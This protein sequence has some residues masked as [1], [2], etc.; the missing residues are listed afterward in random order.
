MNKPPILAIFPQLPLPE[1]AGDRQKVNNLI[2]VLSKHYTINAVVICRESY[3][4]NDENFLSQYCHQYKIFKLSKIGILYNCLKGF[5]KGESLQLNFFYQP[6]IDKYINQNTSNKHF[7]F[8]NLIRTAKYAQHYKGNKVMDMVDLISLSY[9]RSLQKVHSPFWKYIYKYENKHL[10]QAEEKVMN[11]FKDVFL[12]NKNEQELLS[13]KHSNIFWLPN[14]IKE[15]L[16]TNYSNEITEP[17]AIVF[18]GKMDYPPNVDAVIW[19]V[20]N[21]F[22]HLN[23]AIKFYIVGARPSKKVTALSNNRVIVTGYVSDPY[24]LMSNCALVVSPMQTGGGIQN[25]ILEGMALGKINVAT[26]LGASS[27]H[28]ANNNEHL[29]VEDNPLKMAQLINSIVS[30]P[31]AFN[32]IANNGKKLVS[33]IYTWQNFGEILYQQIELSLK[34]IEN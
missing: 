9:Q 2:K 8:Y 12:V 11:T 26:S 3:T 21:V 31:V 33:D 4:T 17:N 22:Q 7:V 10:A 18:I 5:L 14:G 16:F 1:F 19:F 23:S 25:K 15:N 29:L 24:V 13:Q 34:Y 32:H 28:L 30:N 6:K 27:I 20:K